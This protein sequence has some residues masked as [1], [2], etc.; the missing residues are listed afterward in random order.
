MPAISMVWCDVAA[1]TDTIVLFY[2]RQYLLI[3][4][5]DIAVKNVLQ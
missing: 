4:G 2:G 5:F 3:M 1:Q